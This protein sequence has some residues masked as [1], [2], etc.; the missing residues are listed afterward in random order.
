MI[1][2]WG[3]LS[4]LIVVFAWVVLEA[5]RGFKSLQSPMPRGIK[6]LQSPIGL[7]TAPTLMSNLIQLYSILANRE[8][9]R[10]RKWTLAVSRNAYETLRTSRITPHVSRLSAQRNHNTL[11][12]K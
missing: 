11:C 12:L 3:L 4:V 10:Q 5:N 1:M 8:A 6:P 2:Y 9:I 7:A